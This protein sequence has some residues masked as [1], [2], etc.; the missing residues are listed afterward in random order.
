MH[1]AHKC[2]RRF[3]LESVDWAKLVAGHAEKQRAWRA[4][5]PKT[6]SAKQ[7]AA[8]AEKKSGGGSSGGASTGGGGKKICF[9]ADLFEE[10]ELV[11]IFEVEDLSEHA[12]VSDNQLKRIADKID[13]GR[14]RLSELG[15][16]RDGAHDAVD[17]P[18]ALSEA[19]KDLRDVDALRLLVVFSAD[20]FVEHSKEKETRVSVNAQDFA[21][22]P[23]LLQGVS[24]SNLG[25]DVSPRLQFDLKGAG[26][27]NMIRKTYLKEDELQHKAKMHR[28]FSYVFAIK[29]T[30]V[31]PTFHVC[32]CHFH[33]HIASL[34]R[35]FLTKHPR[36]LVLGPT[37]G[38]ATAAAI[39]S[40]PRT[41]AARPRL[42]SNAERLDNLIVRLGEAL[43]R[44]DAF[45]SADFQDELIYIYPLISE[46]S[47]T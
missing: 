32:F 1:N 41:E 22:L 14:E 13:K 37:S 15:T 17:A 42:A 6:Q 26:T 43:L 40:P 18:G 29:T 21:G 33:G 16:P 35:I 3:E 31:R 38:G 47:R 4:E 11:K 10:E 20:S 7:K 25:L 46:V 45:A 27:T 30:M 39:V 44:P 36:Y 5:H 24:G 2:S 8:A 23:P 12:T 9:A 34:T 19:P 28:Y